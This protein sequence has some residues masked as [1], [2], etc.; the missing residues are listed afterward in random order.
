MPHSVSPDLWLLVVSLL[1]N[2][3][4]LAVFINVIRGRGGIAYLRTSFLKENK[5]TV[6]IGSRARREMHATL[7]TPDMRPVVFLGDSITAAFEWGE[8]FAGSTPVLNRGIG[9]DTT[10]GVLERI[11]DVSRLN[12][13]AVFLMIGTNDPQMLAYVPKD[14]LANCRQIIKT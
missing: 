13:V 12:P 10:L 6:D 9:G 11:A 2:L 8:S 14:T 4:G 1:I 7:P 5:A 3:A